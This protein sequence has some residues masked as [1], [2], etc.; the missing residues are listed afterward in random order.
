MVSKSAAA[1]PSPLVSVVS[2]SAPSVVSVASPSPPPQAAR[3]SVKTARSA[4]KRFSFIDLSSMGESRGSPGGRNLTPVEL[5]RPVRRGSASL[6]TRGACSYAC[7]NAVTR[8]RSV[9]HQRSCGPPSPRSRGARAA[10]LGDPSVHTPP[11][12]PHRGPPLAESGRGRIDA[13]PPP[14]VRLPARSPDL[15]RRAPDVCP[16]ARHR[17]TRRLR[18]AAQVRGTVRVPESGREPARRSREQPCLDVL[19]VCPGPCPR[20]L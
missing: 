5:A 9:P 10:R 2:G 12:L 3:T 14:G 6:P 19:V 4:I 18:E 17:A 15:G 11:R 20:R 8:E 7:P 1:P 13:R 16:Q